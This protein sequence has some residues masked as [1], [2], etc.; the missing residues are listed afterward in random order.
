MVLHSYLFLDPNRMD[1]SG[2]HQPE[3]H[4]LLSGH[5]SLQ[6]IH[7]I[8]KDGAVIP[9]LH[10]QALKKDLSPMTLYQLGKNK[11]VP[12]ANTFDS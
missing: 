3:A 2:P 4:F 9:G 7:L 11:L 6:F 12:V 8:V 5:I 1:A 10:E